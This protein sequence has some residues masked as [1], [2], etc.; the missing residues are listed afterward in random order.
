MKRATAK[1][2]S[3][4]IRMLALMKKV[5]PVPEERWSGG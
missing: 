2:K 1:L 3:S 4:L 5:A